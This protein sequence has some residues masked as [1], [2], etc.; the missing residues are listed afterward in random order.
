MQGLPLQRFVRF[1]VDGLSASAGK[2]PRTSTFESHLR[3]VG[4]H[5]IVADVGLCC[6]QA[7]HHLRY[8]NATSATSVVPLT[9]THSASPSQSELGIANLGNTCYL[10]EC[11]S[12]L[13]VCTPLHPM[14]FRSSEFHFCC[15]SKGLTS[16]SGR[17]PCILC[18]LLR[19][20]ETFITPSW[21]PAHPTIQRLVSACFNTQF[22][23][24]TPCTA[25]T[26]RGLLC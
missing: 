18:E 19:F 17:G 4:F 11:L 9:Q 7:L 10:N 1:T 5:G 8:R 2:G 20:S 3:T 13:P 15:K 14:L 25:R 21:F 26:M 6:V 24:G 16:S 12:I 23:N 22:F